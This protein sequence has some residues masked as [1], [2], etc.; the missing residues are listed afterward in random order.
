M[1]VLH[2]RARVLLLLEFHRVIALLVAHVLIIIV[3]V[4]FFSALILAHRMRA[5]R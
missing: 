2:A 3:V 5:A 4:A 1:V